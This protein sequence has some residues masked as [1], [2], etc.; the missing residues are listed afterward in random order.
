MESKE[1]PM[2]KVLM[3]MLTV[4]SLFLL[5]S[6]SNKEEEAEELIEYNN[7]KWVPINKMNNEKLD[8]PI[9]LL[10]TFDDE[11]KDK[12]AITILEDEMIPILNE[13]INKFKDV[14]L[15]H[16]K[17]K[18]LNDLEIEA[19]ELLKDSAKEAIIH[20][21]GG[22]VSEE[23]IQ[24]NNIEIEEKA[25]KLTDYRHELIEEYDLEYVEDDESLG[26]FRELKRE[27]E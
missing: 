21:N 17:I 27:E 2:K 25:L 22:D 3:L 9:K 10:D 16:K 24:Q 4:F 15:Q 18:K 5:V 1:M 12:E 14:N 19:D 13:T 20:Y 8:E 26:N 23:D 11:G 7:D 6:C